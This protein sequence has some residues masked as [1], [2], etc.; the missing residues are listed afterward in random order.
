[1]QAWMEIP[2]LVPEG[3]KEGYDK[4]I[5]EAEDMLTPWFTGGY[6]WDNCQDEIL[7]ACRT[8][9]YEKDGTFRKGMDD[10]SDENGN[11]YDELEEFS[12]VSRRTD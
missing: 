6:I 11:W 7:H 1:V 3:A 12:G 9:Y 10:A 2:E 5:Q 4:G 8:G